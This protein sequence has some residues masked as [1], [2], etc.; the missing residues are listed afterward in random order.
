M[1]CKRFILRHFLNVDLDIL[2]S[3]NGSAKNTQSPSI[4]YRQT[5]DQCQLYAAKFVNGKKS[6]GSILVISNFVLQIKNKNNKKNLKI[7]G[8][9]SVL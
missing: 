4:A 5:P 9:G 6:L 8:Q 3:H 2:Q 7:T 1:V